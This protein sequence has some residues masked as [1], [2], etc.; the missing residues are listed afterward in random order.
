M[1]EQ[2]SPARPAGRAVVRKAGRC[3]RWNEKRRQIFLTHLAKTANVSESTKKA[4]MSLSAAYLLKNRDQVFAHA[5]REALEIGLGELEMKVLLD[6]IH[7]SERIETMEVGED[8]ELKYVKT[9]VQPNFRVAV[10]LLEAHRPEV[11]AFR[12]A[13]DGGTA[14]SRRALLNADMD[15][16]RERLI[17]DGLI[18]RHEADEV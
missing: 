7:G 8:R 16:V 2:D 4:R 10:R 6:S 17:A 14:E 15:R 3:N 5:W 18:D 9:V 11:Q 12:A 13:Q 1:S